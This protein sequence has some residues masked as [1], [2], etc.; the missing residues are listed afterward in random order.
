[1]FRCELT[2]KLSR[3]GLPYVDED[4]PGTA[5]EKPHRIVVETRD[6]VYMRKIFNEERRQYEDVEV[7]RGWEIVREINVSQE[8]FDMWNS[9]SPEQRATWVKARF[10]NK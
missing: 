7:G 6:R 9:W 3:R 5:S 10:Y 2:G 8:G 4:H 1:M